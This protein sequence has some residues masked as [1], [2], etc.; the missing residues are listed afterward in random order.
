M[1]AIMKYEYQHK[2]PCKSNYI[3][4]HN[5]NHNK[6]NNNVLSGSMFSPLSKAVMS[7]APTPRPSDP[8]SSPGGGSFPIAMKTLNEYKFTGANQAPGG[9]LILHN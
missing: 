5:Q 3:H 4:N 8:G 9:V 2:S 7:Q 1:L 6:N